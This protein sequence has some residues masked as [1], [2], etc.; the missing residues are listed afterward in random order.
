MHCSTLI[1]SVNRYK[2]PITTM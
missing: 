2:Y 1:P